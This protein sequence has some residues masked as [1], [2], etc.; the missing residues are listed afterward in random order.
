MKPT[1]VLKKEHRAIET[2]LNILSVVCDK[3]QN[4]EEVNPE[5]LERIMD[6]FK[7]F[8]DKCHHGKEEDLLFPALE[9]CGIPKEGGPVGVMLYEHN[10]GRGYI[11]EMSEAK[12]DKDKI[13]E[14]ARN[15]ISLLSQHI[16]KED[17]ILFQMADIHI[18]EEKQ[19]KL[20]IEFERLEE[21]KIGKGKHEEFHKLLE[22]LKKIY[23]E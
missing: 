8:A 3:L 12:Q 6:F 18:P 15:Y 17:N 9:E 22:E 2:M 1:E 14:N 11:K 16:Q 5:H 7:I 4:E 13:V 10:I 19:Q 20:L 23:L 21:E